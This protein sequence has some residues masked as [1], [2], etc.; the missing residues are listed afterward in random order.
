MLYA[1]RD[2]L[3]KKLDALYA[4]KRESSSRYREASDAHWAKQQEDRAKRTERAK[5]ARHAAEMEK[6]K[7]I[8]ERLREEAQAPAYQTEIE[9]CQNLIDYFSGTTTASATGLETTRSKLSAVPELSLRQVEA[10]TNGLIEVKRQDEEE[11]FVSSEWSW[12]E[13]VFARTLMN[14]GSVGKKS[15]KGGKGPKTTAEP[16][17]ERFSVPLAKLSALASLSIPPPAT[18]AEIPQT[19]ENLKTK[20]EWLM[21][22]QAKETEANRAKVEKEIA[23]LLKSIEGQQE[24]G[25]IDDAEETSVPE[26]VAV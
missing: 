12:G 21:A 10:D 17:G 4:K 18:A 1:E 7:E 16:S 3:Q 20:R 9:D 5:A 14:L 15:K 13:H 11:F 19:I 22:N 23:R 24:N 2:Q 6:K 26:P 25:A 8:V